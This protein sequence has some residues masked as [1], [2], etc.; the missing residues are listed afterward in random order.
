MFDAIDQA[1]TFEHERSTNKENCIPYNKKSM[2]GRSTALDE[3]V[4]EYFVYS[5]LKVLLPKKSPKAAI[6]AEARIKRELRS[7]F[8]H[9]LQAM[10]VN[11]DCY[12]RICLREISYRK[13]LT[14]NPHGISRE[15]SKVVY[16]LEGCGAIIRCNGFMDRRSGRTKTTRIRPCLT[17]LEDLKMLP[18]DIA[19]VF[20]EPPAVCIRRGMPENLDHAFAQHLSRMQKTV[21]DYN[22]FMRSHTVKIPNEKN[23]VLVFRGGDGRP[24][25]VNASGKT[26]TAIYHAN[27]AGKLSYGRIHGGAWQVIPATYRRSILIDGHDTVELDYSAQVVHIVAGLE[28]IQLTGDPYAIPLPFTD[29]DAD[30]AREVVKSAIVI[31]LNTSN[32]K[33]M[34]GALRNKFRCDPR[35]ENRSI[36]PKLIRE[37]ILAHHPFLEKY[38]MKGVGKDLFMHDAEIARQII[39]TFLDQGKVVLSIHD[40]FIVKKSDEQLLRDTM[41]RV[42]FENFG[43][44][45]PIKAEI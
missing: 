25:W 35:T 41:Q 8:W 19:E 36:R 7:L 28:G 32:L 5:G 42:W 10:R 27:D 26:L 14:D 31:M 13:S 29:Y 11:D 34:N 39:Q 15:I 33:A 17:L 22:E 12:V 6:S 3:L 30:F 16:A 37:C 21:N 20:I 9:F 45:I 2:A 38:A 1:N 18:T 40:G 24:H 43:T 4:N 23:G 44:T